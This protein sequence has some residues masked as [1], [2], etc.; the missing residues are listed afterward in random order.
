MDIF[1]LRNAKETRTA[2]ATI[3]QGPI[4]QKKTAVHSVKPKTTQRFDNP[5]SEPIELAFINISKM[6]LSRF[7]SDKLLHVL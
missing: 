3:V 6:N 2:T 7:S 4:D 5:K 1:I